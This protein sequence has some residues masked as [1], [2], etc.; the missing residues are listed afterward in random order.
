MVLQSIRRGEKE[1]GKKER[2]RRLQAMQF[3]AG[4][5]G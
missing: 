5:P 4:T 2:K 3:K 1:K